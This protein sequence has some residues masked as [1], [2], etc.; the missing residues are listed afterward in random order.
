MDFVLYSIGAQRVKNDCIAFRS[1]CE[2]QNIEGWVISLYLILQI[3][4][5]FSINVLSNSFFLS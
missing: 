4:L 3:V 1:F 5:L 2:E